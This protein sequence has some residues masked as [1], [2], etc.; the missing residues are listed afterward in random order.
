MGLSCGFVVVLFGNRLSS[1]SSY[2]SRFKAKQRGLESKRTSDE[3]SEPHAKRGARLS[4]VRED[5]GCVDREDAGRVLLF[6]GKRSKVLWTRFGNVKQEGKVL[7]AIVT[8]VSAAS[9]TVEG[10]MVGATPGGLLV[11]LGIK[12]GD[13]TGAVKKLAEKVCR[14]RIFEDDAGKMNLDL[15][16]AGGSLLV[17]SQ[18]TLYADTRSRR[19][20]FTDAALPE[21]AIPLY[22]QFIE[23]CKTL[24]F[25]VEAG[26]FGADMQVES[27]NDGPVTI[28]LD[29]D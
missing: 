5:A 22:E 24:G 15:S 19:P 2:R 3:A 17:V 20:G 10:Q 27:V 21:A 16:V 12:K 25:H 9:V 7:R 18:F 11:L 26:V 1:P 6:A 13:S 8:R 4:A 14:L 28:I 23:E 29:V